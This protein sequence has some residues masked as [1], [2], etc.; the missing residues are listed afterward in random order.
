MHRRTLLTATAAV[1][2]Q[3]ALAQSAYPD[4][5]LRMIIPWPPGQATDLIG[6]LIAQKLGE[7][8][9]QTVV[10][11]NRA[12]AGG[13]IGTDAAAKAQPDGYTLLAASAGPMTISPLVQRVSYDP[14]KDFAPV[15]M[16]SNS[17]YVLVVR[18]NFPA[19]DIA[20]FVAEVKANPGRYTFS[21]SGTGAAAHLI[22]EWFNHRAGFNVVHVP[23]AGSI[24]GL[25][26][27]MAG[28]VDYAME[29][30][31]ATGPMFRQGQLRALGISL[32]KGSTLA[33]DIPPIATAA[34]MPGYD[35]GAWGGLMVPARTP[36]P[37][38]QRLSAA[39]DGIMRTPDMLARFAAIGVEVDYRPA[40]AFATLLRQQSTMFSDIIRT[41]NI[42]VE[43]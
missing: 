24:P 18:P 27:V 1:L 35:I 13:Q 39:M 42:K 23:F 31:A 17:P 43:Q 8:F 6:R 26:A 3:P 30:L 34:N 28:Q 16:T 4:R 9:G 11:E 19:R 41:A 7:A 38:I 32:A 10:A 25:T 20:G 36:Q 15:A 14:E 12:G 21:S 2:T 37:V 40:E 29:T 22:C 33:P 5:T